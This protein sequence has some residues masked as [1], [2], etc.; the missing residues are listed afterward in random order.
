MIYV[1]YTVSDTLHNLFVLHI[2]KETDNHTTEEKHSHIDC[3]DD[4]IQVLIGE[5]TLLQAFVEKV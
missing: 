2:V 3:A 1:V 5:Q 4:F